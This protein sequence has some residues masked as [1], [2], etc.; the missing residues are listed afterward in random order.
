[1]TAFADHGGA[2]QRHNASKIGLLGG[3]FNPAHAG[4]REI[5]IAA[6]KH[7]NLDAVW[8]LVTPG[9]PLKNPD[10]YAPYEDRMRMARRVAGH[11]RLVVS[12]FEQRKNTQYT[13]D[14]IDA[15]QTLW[16]DMRFLWLM[17]ADSLE[18][19]H[20]WRDWR[21]IAQMIPFAVFNRPGS[22]TAADQSIAGKELSAFR[23]E[24][25]DL[26]SMLHRVSPIDPPVWAFMPATAN[27]LSSTA[28]R[29]QCRQTSDETP[30]GPGPADET[31]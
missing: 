12:N 27:P 5:S 11:H 21:R 20:A 29:E 6:L 10:E 26:A 13:V 9:N 25:N 31:Q 15:L 3:S 4:H 2:P 14:T 17:G 18:N 24:T 7:F 23:V 19:F 30:P 16:P 8:W 1:M 28:L 22:E